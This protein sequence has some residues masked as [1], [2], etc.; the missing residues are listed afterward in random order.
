MAAAMLLVNQGIATRVVSVP[1]PHI[2]ARL[3]APRRTALFGRRAL[4]VTI[5]AH[6]DLDWSP[7]LGRAPALRIHVDRYGAGG[8]AREAA[9]HAGLE[10]DRIAALIAAQLRGS[11]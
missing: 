8:S 4:P 1:L 11:R 5:F 6:G 9:C 7:L 10:P 2:A 3:P